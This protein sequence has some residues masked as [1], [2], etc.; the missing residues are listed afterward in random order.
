MAPDGPEVVLGVDVGTT[1]AKTVA[2]DAAG[3]ILGA[4]EG[5]YPMH[6]PEHGHAEQDP[7]QMLETVL[8][9]RRARHGKAA[10]GSPGCRSARPCTRSWASTPAGSRSRRS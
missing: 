10:H 2:F 4:A 9:T 1:S 7:A 8:A 5:G 3:E 6:E